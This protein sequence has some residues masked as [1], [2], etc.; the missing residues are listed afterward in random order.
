MADAQIKVNA[1][2][3]EKRR[4]RLQKEAE[5]AAELRRI[6]IKNQFLEADKEAVERKKT[7]SQQAGEQREI[8]E[9]QTTKLVEAR[10]GMAVLNKEAQQ[11]LLNVQREREAH[12]AFM[13]EYEA[14]FATA[15]DEA[16]QLEADYQYMQEEKLATRKALKA[17]KEASLAWS[18]PL[19]TI[20]MTQSLA[21][22]SMR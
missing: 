13:A 22:D 18:Q 17:T 11:R 8:I 7:E 1:K 21:G 12:E 9:R 6:A 16:Q 4:E 20:H 15:R 10:A 2:L 14:H 3:E 19:P 5:L